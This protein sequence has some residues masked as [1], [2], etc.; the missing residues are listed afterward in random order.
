MWYL[1]LLKPAEIYVIIHEGWHARAHITSTHLAVRELRH[2]R[3]RTKNCRGNRNMEAST[4]SND[5]SVTITT[6]GVIRNCL[7]KPKGERASGCLNS[8]AAPNT[9]ARFG[10][11]AKLMFDTVQNAYLLRFAVCEIWSESSKPKC[12]HA[13]HLCTLSITWFSYSVDDLGLRP[14]WISVLILNYLIFTKL[15]F[16]AKFSHLPADIDL[17]TQNCQS[18]GLLN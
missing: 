7:G 14:K 15:N 9:A 1:F 18:C 11:T 3:K 8:S 6:T 5:K 17:H 16:S 13:A 10:E 12:L 4:L 2:Y